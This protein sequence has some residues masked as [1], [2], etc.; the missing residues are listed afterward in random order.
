M[1]L[2]LCLKC[3]DIFK[4]DYEKRSCKCGEVTGRYVN[5][6]DAETNG[7][8][9]SLAIGTGS[10]ERAIRNLKQLGD[11]EDR[12]FYID[13]N[14][15]KCWVRPN[16]GSG[17]PNTKVIE[18]AFEVST[19]TEESTKPTIQIDS[20]LSQDEMDLLKVKWQIRYAYL[21]E[22]GL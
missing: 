2:L 3:Q 4:L 14:S 15:V 9:I 12:R 7:N 10:L 18:E 8:G 19:T 21:V 11:K 17:N 1:K 16:E 20:T 6:M 5:E 13:E 22:K